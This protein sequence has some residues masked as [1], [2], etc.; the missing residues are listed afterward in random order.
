M[1]IFQ[2]QRSPFDIDKRDLRRRLGLGVEEKVL[3]LPGNER[4]SALHQRIVRCGLPV[5]PEQ[6][7]G[8]HGAGDARHD[9]AAD[10]PA[11]GEWLRHSFVYNHD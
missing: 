9:Q 5:W 7:S 2:R 6:Q 3:D 4:V 10:Q 11:A 8:N 1:K